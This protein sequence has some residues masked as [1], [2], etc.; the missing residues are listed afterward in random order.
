MRSSRIKLSTDEKF[1]FAAALA[2]RDKKSHFQVL[3]I[4]PRR[5]SS[6]LQGQVEAFRRDILQDEFADLITFVAYEEYADLLAATRSERA[7]ELPRFLVGRI[8]EGSEMSQ[9]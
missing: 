7:A 9:V 4:G 2:E 8:H 1:S 5:F 6:V 3:T